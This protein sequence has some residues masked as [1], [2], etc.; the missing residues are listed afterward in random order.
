[1]PLWKLQTVG[2]QQFDFL[3]PSVGQGTIVT[4]RPGIATCFRKFY[5]MVSDILRGAWIRHVRRY[6][7]ELLGTTTDLT[8]FMF[9]S[10][11]AQL[12]TIREVLLE[13]GPSRCFYCDKD[14]PSQAGNVDH[15]VP[16][17]RYPVDLGHN[18]VLAH[19]TCNSSKSDHVASAEYLEKWVEHPRALF[20]LIDRTA[21]DQ[22][23]DSSVSSPITSLFSIN[24]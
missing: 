13:T 18:F 16:W 4:L 24:C 19:N 11:R 22:S 20:E 14:L 12:G 10:E 15:F 21:P 5:A 23:Q 6:N 2:S 7:C 8:E 17:A 1:M 9:G 3:Y